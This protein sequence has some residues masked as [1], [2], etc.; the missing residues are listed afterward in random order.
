M[1]KIMNKLVPFM[2]VFALMFAF[3]ADVS[4]ETVQQADAIEIATAEDLLAINENL[5]G[6]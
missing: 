5:T 4:A 2:L 6:H 1:K 3:G